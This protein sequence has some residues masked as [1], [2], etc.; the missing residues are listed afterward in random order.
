MTPWPKA[1]L[2]FN[3]TLEPYTYD[4]EK[5]KNHMR[6]AGYVYPTDKTG[7]GIMF[8]IIIGILAL[9]GGSIAGK[10]SKL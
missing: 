4:L 1:G 2:Y 8:P 3:E 7:I 9:L 10:R 5:A 6:A